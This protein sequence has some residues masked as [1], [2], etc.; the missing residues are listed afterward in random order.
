LTS[1]NLCEGYGGKFGRAFN[2][3]KGLSTE[4]FMKKDT[5]FRKEFQYSL[6][7]EDILYIPGEK[8]RKEGHSQAFTLNLFLPSANIKKQD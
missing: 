2:K 8:I 5:K 1:D 3:F 6:I 7:K 4:D